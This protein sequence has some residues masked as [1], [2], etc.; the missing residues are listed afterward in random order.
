MLIK[1]K[2]KVIVLKSDR[3][4]RPKVTKEHLQP[5]IKVVLKVEG[6]GRLE[7]S[8]LEGSIALGVG[9]GRH[10]LNRQPV[11]VENGVHVATKGLKVHANPPDPD[12]HHIDPMMFPRGLPI[13]VPNGLRGVTIPTNLPKFT[14]S[15]YEDPATH[16]ERFVEVLIASL[17]T[18]HD[19]FFI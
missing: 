2:T 10:P 3:V 11:G 12:I 9:R 14:S 17:V 5:V 16:V 19:Y 13:I 8:T 18:D 1:P 7:D 15:L 6:K 4:L